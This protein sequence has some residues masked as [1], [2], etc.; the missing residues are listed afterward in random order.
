MLK[1]NKI[2]TSDKN[3]YRVEKQLGKGG[4]SVHKVQC[5]ASNNEYTNI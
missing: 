5:L 2:L 1:I 3:K 4:S